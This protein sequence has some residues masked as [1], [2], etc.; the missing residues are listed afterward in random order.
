MKT[1]RD[2][3]NLHISFEESLI[4]TTVVR[5]KQACHTELTNQPD[6]NAVKVDLSQ[7]EMIDSL[8]LNFLVSLFGDVQKNG[9]SFAISGISE[10]NRKLFELVNLQEHMKLN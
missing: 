9:W 3:D 1:Q 7:V 6:I 5:L 4:S 10:A 2:H 8:G